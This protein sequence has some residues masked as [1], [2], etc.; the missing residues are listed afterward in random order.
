MLSE[1]RPDK[2]TEILHA[3]LP[4]FGHFG[5]RKTSVEDLARAAGLS[6]Q[7]LYLHFRSKEEIFVAAL[8]LYLDEGLDLVDAALGLKG[9][10]LIER[11]AEAMDTWFG[12]HLVT[13]TPDAFDVIE[14]GNHLSRDVIDGYKTAFRSRL[15]ATIT[16]SSEFEAAKRIVSP[17][18]LASV[19]FTFGLTWKEGWVSRMEFA[20]MLNLC[21]TACIS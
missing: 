18:E 11:L 16:N 12:R 7:G 8:L 9:A 4:V 10:S 13:F 6:K 3:V 15:E 21:V 2:T 20:K 14:A 1:C 5:F 19:L 17:E